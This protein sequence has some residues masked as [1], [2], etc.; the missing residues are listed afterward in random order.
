MYE[1]RQEHILGA[2]RCFL[3]SVTNSSREHKFF[4]EDCLKIL[5]LISMGNEA[6]KLIEELNSHYKKIPSEGLIEIIPQIIARLDNHID[7]NKHYVEIMRNLLVYVGSKHPQALLFP[8]IFLRRGNNQ[9]KKELANAIYDDIAQNNHSFESLYG[10][11][12]LIV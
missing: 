9:F 12:K 4:L 7:Q 1:R 3:K 2:L 6:A 11:G 5:N 10:D 8:L